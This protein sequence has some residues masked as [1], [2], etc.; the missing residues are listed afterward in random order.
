MMTVN[1]SSISS[2][3]RILDAETLMEQKNIHQLV[4]VDQ[5]HRLLGLMPFRGSGSN[6]CS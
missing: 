1:P 3:Q 4:V 5:Q 6:G 2:D